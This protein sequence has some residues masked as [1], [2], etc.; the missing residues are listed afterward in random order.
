MWNAVETAG[1]NEVQVDILDKSDQIPV[2]EGMALGFV[3]YGTVIVRHRELADCDPPNPAG[4]S[5]SYLQHDVTAGLPAGYKS[6]NFQFEDSGAT[7]NIDSE[8]AIRAL[9]EQGR[10]M[11]YLQE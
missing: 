5:Q 11:L 2:Q 8:F 1:V 7:I 9:I 3:G 6:Q 10:S 4:C